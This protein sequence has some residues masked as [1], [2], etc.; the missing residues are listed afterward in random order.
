MIVYPSILHACLTDKRDVVAG[1][2]IVR[3][4]VRKNY[5]IHLGPRKWFVRV[6]AC[7]RARVCMLRRY[8]S[9]P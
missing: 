3:L 4:Y 6:R 1:I 9:S 2:V 7:V 8:R 5:F